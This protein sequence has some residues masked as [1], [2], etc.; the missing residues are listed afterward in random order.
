MYDFYVYTFAN[1]P[2]FK[3]VKEIIAEYGLLGALGKDPYL[4]D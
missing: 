4:R 3:F 1:W 2:L